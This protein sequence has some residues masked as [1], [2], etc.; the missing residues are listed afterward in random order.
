M[1]DDESV[2]GGVK[3][4]VGEM[5]DPDRSVRFGEHAEADLQQIHVDECDLCPVDE[6]WSKSKRWVTLALPFDSGIVDVGS[7]TVVP[8]ARSDS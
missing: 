8:P 7:L 1:P 5:L 6:C 4:V 2:L 3:G